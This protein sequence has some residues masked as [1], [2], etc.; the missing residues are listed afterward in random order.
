M[1]MH[2]QL[3]SGA[4]NV[5]FTAPNKFTFKLPSQYESGDND[6]VSLKSLRLYYSWFNITAAKKN[7]SFSYTWS[8]NTVHTVTLPDGIWDYANFQKYLEQV[9]FSK[10]HYLLDSNNRPVYYIKFESNSVFYRISLS[11]SA[12]P[13]V[14]PSGYTAPAGW[15]APATNKTPLVNIPATAIRSY[16]GFETGSYPPVAQATLYQV[17]GANVP[18][19]TDMTSLM[20]Q[21]NLVNNEYG[22]DAR[23]LSSFNVEPGAAAGSLIS[24]VPFYQD[25]I[26]VQPM[27]K[28]RQ[29]TLSLVDQNSRPVKIEDTAGFICTLNLERK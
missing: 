11:V 13:A 9:M 4:P 26:P 16:L 15:V 25:W 17:N 7:N 21:S 2:L 1:S 14:L 19:V 24:E 18:Q 10:K 29:I 3:V 27:S 8:D 28:F 23:T 20:I 5:T 22:P 6:R 12:V